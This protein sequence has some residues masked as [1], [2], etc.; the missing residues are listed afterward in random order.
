MSEY[1]LAQS[2]YTHVAQ[3]S[4]HSVLDLND[5][6]VERRRGRARE[7]R[8]LSATRPLPL[9]VKLFM[10]GLLIPWIIPL[11]PLNL[12]AYR[13][14]LL[15]ALLPCIAIFA[16]GKAGSVR[17]ADVGLFLYSLWIALSFAV[18][19]GVGVAMQSGG[20]M[21][22]DGMGA[23]LL[24]RCYIRNANDFRNMIIFAIK[25]LACLMPFAL[26]EWTTGQKPLLATFRMIFPTV[27]VTMMTPRLGLWR[28]QGPFGHSI[29][30]GVF[31]GSLLALAGL[32]ASK[33][34][35]TRYLAVCLVGGTTVMSMS[36][37]PIAGIFFQLALLAW[38]AALGDFKWRWKLLWVIALI[39]YLIIEF[40][41]NQTPIQFYI[42]HFT[43]DQQ[44]GWYRIWIWNYGSASVG[45]H[46][47]FGIGLGDWARPKWMVSDSVD[48]FWLLTA[49]RY[50]LP[51]FGLLIVS[52]LFLW[53]Q[54]ARR[55]DMDRDLQA[56]RTAYLICMATF[57]FVGSTVHFW[58]AVYAWLFFLSG[59]G[60]WLLDAKSDE[61]DEDTRLALPRTNRVNPSAR[62]RDNAKPQR[63]GSR[64]PAV[65]PSVAV[66]EAPKND[67]S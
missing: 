64:P 65:R 50:G 43:F 6:P 8:N 25:L 47:I 26:Y 62:E 63:L 37:A 11:G 18:I 53:I 58:V 45:D 44:T 39:G 27:D 38:N 35:S 1:K 16:Q 22:I 36:S 32:V 19:H 20:M 10:I 67:G 24:A 33:K 30:F 60:V 66:V 13:I 56:Y 48:N 3:A 57:V 17:A 14:V 4:T 34:P 15:G 12:F 31:C 61:G 41:S 42:S 23:Y 28:V 5:V 59:A 40:G 2:R 55:K 7:Q 21:F 49:M 51:A 46:P 29:L 54:I 52:W 9:P